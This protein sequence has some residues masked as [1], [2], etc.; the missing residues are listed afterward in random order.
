MKLISFST[1]INPHQI[2]R[3]E[4]GK[5]D[6]IYEFKIPK[7]Y[8]AFIQQVGNTWFLNTHLIW[9]V[10]WHILTLERQIAPL[11][12]PKEFNPPILA[13]DTIRWIGFNNDTIPHF[14]E[15]LCDG[16]LLKVE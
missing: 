6:I 5:S 15:V 1:F 14:F 11:N 12:S 9:A 2:K 4:P 16:V 3:I 8:V 10:D 7:G 13:K